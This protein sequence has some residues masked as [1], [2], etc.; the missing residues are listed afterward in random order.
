MFDAG[1]HRLIELF[2][3]KFFYIIS[4]SFNGSVI[5]APNSN[6]NEIATMVI[7]TT[8]ASDSAAK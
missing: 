4:L 3:V 1:C 5:T 6:P 8:V 2:V 7:A